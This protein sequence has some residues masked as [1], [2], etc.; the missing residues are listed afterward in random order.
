MPLLGRG[1]KPGIVSEIALATFGLA[2]VTIEPLGQRF[3]RARGWIRQFESDMPS[4]A[5]QS[6]PRM[7]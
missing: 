2:G 4:Q 5:A 3:Q 6:L 1:L 7:S